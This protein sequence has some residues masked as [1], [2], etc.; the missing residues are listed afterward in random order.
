MVCNLAPRL[1]GNVSCAAP[2]SKSKTIARWGAG[3]T[4]TNKPGTSD[5]L[6]NAPHEL[7]QFDFILEFNVH[8][9]IVTVKRV[10]NHS[11]ER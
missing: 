7:D 9:D 3:L 8:D 6:S 1:F 2:L 10:G 5:G 11:P 4:E